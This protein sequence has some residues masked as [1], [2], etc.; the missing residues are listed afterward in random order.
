VAGD[1]VAIEDLGSKNG[2]R[3]R[4]RRIA[5]PTLLADG[6]EI[7]LGHEAVLLVAATS[8]ATTDTDKLSSRPPRG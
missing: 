1:R 4:G 8:T 7:L 6:E 3:V 2:T 5:G